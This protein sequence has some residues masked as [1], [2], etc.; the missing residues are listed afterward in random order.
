MNRQPTLAQLRDDLA[1]GRTTSRQLVEECLSHIA[2]P[3]GEGART[4]LKVNAEGARA[5]AD[6]MDLLRKAKAMPSPFAGIPI[7]V[8]DLF[9]VAGEVTAAGSRVLADKPPAELDAPA[10]ARLR[11]AGFVVIGRTNMTEF[12]YSGLGLNPHYDTPRSPWRREEG[13]I[14]GGSSSGAA[15]SVADGMAHGAIGTDTGGSCRIPAAFCGIVGYKPTARRVPLDGV[16]PLASSLDSVGPL[17][18]SVACC[19]VLDA[20]LAG[21]PLREL[22]PA[23]LEGLRLMVPTTIALDDLAPEVASAFTVALVGL[24]MAGARILE[25]PFPEFTEIFGKS[26]FVAAESYAWHRPLIETEE[27]RYDP[28]VARRIRYGAARSAADYLDMIAA[29]RSIVARATVRLADIDALV[30]PTVAILPPRLADLASD[31]A[32]TAANMLALRN[33]TLI[34][35]IDGCAISIPIRAARDAPV[36]LMIAGPAGADHRLF[37]IAAAVEAAL[38]GEAPARG[39]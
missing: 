9:D 34:N 38:A 37:A 7:S 14:P 20:V 21:E 17:A 31:E 2:D 28:R 3:A 16:V 15:V 1:T 24:E 22:V 18:R 4:F 25:K 39:L 10:I 12:A 5:A 29:R 8:K 13:R 36:G 23:P 27:A 11:R 35:M 32:F 6:A 26:G 19:A 33:T 30:M